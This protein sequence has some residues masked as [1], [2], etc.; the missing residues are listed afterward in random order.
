MPIAIS[1]KERFP[2]VLERERL[3]VKDSTTPAEG[4]T[5]FYISAPTY[6]FKADVLDRSPSISQDGDE[7]RGRVPMGTVLRTAVRNHLVGWDEDTFLDGDGE[8]V[9]FVARPGGGA[10]EVSLERLAWADV[11]EIADA[12]LGL[13]SLTEEERGK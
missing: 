8:P 13:G 1:P 6:R 7:I 3:D 10:A 9:P 4:G 2:F 12:I 5:V 11:A